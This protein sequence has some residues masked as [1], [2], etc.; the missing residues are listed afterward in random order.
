VRHELDRSLNGRHQRSESA[1]PVINYRDARPGE[2]VA[3]DLSRP[4][5]SS[6]PY[7]QRPS[8]HTGIVGAMSARPPEDVAQ[9]MKL[10]PPAHSHH[11]RADAPSDHILPD[12]STVSHR[13]P[14]KN[15]PSSRAHAIC[16]HL[17]PTDVP[18]PRDDVTWPKRR[19][20]PAPLQYLPPTPCTITASA[21]GPV[22]K[23]SATSSGPPPLIHE[24]LKG[25]GTGSIVLGTPL[26]PEQRRRHFELP[27][28]VGMLYKGGTDP[29]MMRAGFSVGPPIAPPPP[30]L[31]PQDGQ[32]PIIARQSAGVPW[33]PNP[34][35]QP[36]QSVIRATGDVNV[37]TSSRDLLYGDLM[38]ARQMHRN[39][40]ATLTD[41]TTNDRRQISPH[42]AGSYGPPSWPRSGGRT[43]LIGGPPYFDDMHRADILNTMLPWPVRPPANVTRYSVCGEPSRQCYTPPLPIHKAIVGREPVISRGTFPSNDRL[44]RGHDH[45]DLSVPGRGVPDFSHGS[46][47]RISPCYRDM[48]EN[49]SDWHRSDLRHSPAVD[50]REL[51]SDSSSH[52]PSDNQGSSIQGP[53]VTSSSD[54]MTAANLIDAI[55]ID[56]INQEPGPSGLPAKPCVPSSSQ[57]AAV[58]AAV[59]AVSSVS[60]VSRLRTDTSI[61]NQPTAGSG[62]S[63]VLCSPEK[64]QRRSPAD[65]DHSSHKDLTL[66]E[67]IHSIIMDDFK[68]KDRDDADGLA[69]DAAINNG[70]FYFLVMLYSHCH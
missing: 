11:R 47:A 63:P 32:F 14:A 58:M 4:L 42:A 21:S 37:P 12:G 27:P 64:Q 2:H 28:A 3:E 44:A 66:G 7:Y 17:P 29:N 39:Q 38:T 33:P 65:T 13:S 51:S 1:N 26:S 61:G 16:D 52:R 62:V 49:I 48:A 55:I 10:P 20:V 25:V 36:Q 24:P 59:V 40:A 15:M 50:S 69:F 30:P 23:F 31:P 35:Q 45:A 22:P 43:E 70:M 34:M 54:Q 19:T 53:A 6:Y 5:S 8:A 67:H 9:P 46:D 68:P 41:N 56:Q 60:A 57:A 18:S